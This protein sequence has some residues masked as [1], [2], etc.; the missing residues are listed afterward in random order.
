[1]SRVLILIS[2]SLFAFGIFGQ[3]QKT[4]NYRKFD[5]KLIHFGCL[6][7]GNM[8]DF[9]MS[10]VPDAYNKYQLISLEN[11]AQPGG[12]IG[13]MSTMKLGTPMLRLRF[14]PSLSFQERSLKYYSVSED[15]QSDKD[16][17]NEERINS[18]NIDF[19]FLLQ[20]RT[21]RYNN[22]AAYAIGGIQYTLDLQSSEDSNQSL[23]D[24]FVKIK[25]TD[26]QAQAGVGV[27]F[28]AVF[29][30]FGMEIK[31][32]HG[33]NNVLIQDYTPVSLPLDHL[34]NRVWTF[35]LIF[36]G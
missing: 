23:I 36:E 14:V 20:Y 2:F 10:V 34:K 6:L 31:Y 22:F 9:G 26:W 24:P 29:F 19:P 4:Q 7:G 12:Q 3:K 16:A 30:K 32:S 18:T 25:K 5:Q 28:F 8:A 17:F 1:M 35:S 15:P 27:E 33:F 21:L 13:I 11:G